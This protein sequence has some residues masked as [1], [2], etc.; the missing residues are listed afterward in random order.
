MRLYKESQKWLT[1]SS[2]EER[3]IPKSAGFRWDPA[4]RTWWTDDINK[5]RRLI[6]HAD[7]ELVDE[8]KQA[9][10]DRRDAL[11]ASAAVSADV[12]IPAPAGLEYLPYQRA[13]I[14]FSLGKDAV[15]I[16]DEMG[17]GKTIQALG[18]ANASKAK[19]ILIVCPASLRLNWQREAEKWLVEDLT[20]GLVNKGKCPA[21]ADVLIINYDVLS[22]HRK[23]I[24]LYEWDLL[25]ADEA[26]YAKNPK[27]ARTK[28]LVGHWNYKKK[29]WTKEP[30]KAKRRVLLTGTPIVNRPI[31]LWPLVSYLDPDEWDNF[32]RYARRYAN[33]HN[34]GFG[35][36]FSGAANLEEL[37][38]KLRSTILI[39]RLKADVL[40]D[41][42]AKRRQ[43][44]E[45]PANGASS[46]VAA[47][48][49]AWQSQEDRLS[50]L[51]SA[52]QLAKVAEDTSA[53]R[54]AVEALREGARVAFGEMAKVR[55]ETARAKT[56]YV[57]DHVADAADGQQVIVFA[58]HLDVIDIIA[59]GLRDR[60]LRVVTL[61]GND[62]M[63]ARQSAVDSFQ[64]G[65]ADV[66]VGNL[67]A[68]GV[69]LTLTASSHVV[70]AELDWVPATLSQ[71]EDR[72][73]RIGQ[74]ESVLVQHLVIEGSLDATIA[75]QVV[76]KQRVIDAA[77]DNEIEL[78]DKITLIPVERSVEVTDKEIAQPTLPAD[79]I[80]A[81]HEGLK[82]LSAYCDGAREEDNMGFNK[83]DTSIGHSLASATTLSPKQALLGRKL[84]NKYRRQLS[85]DL[86]E[87]AKKEQ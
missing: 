87:I 50:D 30:I 85:P 55:H 22:K 45:I 68:A 78:D 61:T 76:A 84:V 16:G 6:D 54:E 57:V 17:L 81:I 60:G 59:T 37:Q 75:E 18:I 10:Q 35:W 52:V 41:L 23:T 40:A 11:A 28:A 53:Y 74:T 51:R 32:F 3:H 47:E 58:H 24:D 56:S 2:F 9:D 73:H 29:E 43:V 82:I 44:I 62:S 8:L 71:A 66:F 49:A 69:G 65:H 38:E 19:K 70:F 39:R 64:A 21:D 34:N 48:Q 26:H 67:R 31:E 27:A 25:I 42:P 14:Q 1:E 7:S 13:G 5:A 46:V 72:A 12:E 80:A 83:F 77:L 63:T 20:I 36:D 4:A 15:L 33:A 86:V 79:S